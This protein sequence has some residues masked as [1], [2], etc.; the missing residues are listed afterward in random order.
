MQLRLRSAQHRYTRSQTR[1]EVLI[2]VG[3]SVFFID[4]IYPLLPFPLFNDKGNYPH[5]SHLR[6]YNEYQSSASNRNIKL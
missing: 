3:F 2:T 1:K 4:L 6:D 5:V